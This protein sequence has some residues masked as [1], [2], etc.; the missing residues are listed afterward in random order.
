MS[1]SDKD[2]IEAIIRILKHAL[3]VLIELLKKL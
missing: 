3:G 2:K 1:I